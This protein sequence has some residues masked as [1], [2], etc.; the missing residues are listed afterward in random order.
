MASLRR[1]CKLIARHLSWSANYIGFSEGLHDADSA[2]LMAGVLGWRPD[3][4]TPQYQRLGMAAMLVNSG[5]DARALMWNAATSFYATNKDY[6]YRRAQRQH[7]D[8]QN[9][10]ISIHWKANEYQYNEGVDDN[11]VIRTK[12][13][14]NGKDRWGPWTWYDTEGLLKSQGFHFNNRQYGYWRY[15]DTNGVR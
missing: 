3:Q 9:G 2:R 12:G 10:K 6:F 13:Y 4:D 5:D 1:D 8:I 11:G 7:A 15:Y 14:L